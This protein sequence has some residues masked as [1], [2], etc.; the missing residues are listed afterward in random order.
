MIVLKVHGPMKDKIEDVN[1]SFYEQLECV[2]NTFPNYRVKIL[3]GDFNHKV[4][5][6]DI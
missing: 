5:K 1:D 6:E 2:F 4:G 3:L